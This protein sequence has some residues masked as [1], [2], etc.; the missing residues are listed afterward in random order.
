MKHQTITVLLLLSSFTSLFAQQEIY[1]DNTPKE[2][3]TLNNV[4][5]VEISGNIITD[6]SDLF[7]PFYMDLNYQF[8]YFQELR[9]FSSVGII[10]KGGVT[11]QRR[12]FMKDY[13]SY[14]DNDQY[15]ALSKAIDYFSKRTFGEAHVVV[16]PRWYFSYF[17]RQK[18]GK[19]TLNSGWY[20]G[21]PIEL[22]S[23]LNTY[24]GFRLN[25]SLGFRQAITKSLFIEG[26]LGVM[27]IFHI[28]PKFHINYTSYS[29]TASLKLAYC[30]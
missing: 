3:I 20:I 16:E 17:Y 21:M 12:L 30:L 7:N 27:P 5:G 23:D 25:P 6:G 28:Y 14:S 8:N 22:Y 15:S 24:Y 19:A 9:L 10:L 1:L 29:P 2:K 4:R 11:L 26:G 18:E 13:P